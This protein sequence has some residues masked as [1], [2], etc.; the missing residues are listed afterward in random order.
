MFNFFKSLD[1]PTPLKSDIINESSLAL[2][3][4]LN[5]MTNFKIHQNLFKYWFTL[6]QFAMDHP[7][8]FHLEVATILNLF[9][10][11]LQALGELC[12]R[13]LWAG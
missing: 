5:A 9:F 10:K 12:Q 7:V 2:G 11:I 8:L 13:H 1:P 3:T 4:I 6:L